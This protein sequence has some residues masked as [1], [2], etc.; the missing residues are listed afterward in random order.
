MR[1][2]PCCTMLEPLY[3]VSIVSSFFI[4]PG[5]GCSRSSTLSG[6]ILRKVLLESVLP[7]APVSTFALN[8]WVP[9]IS[10]SLTCSSVNISARLSLCCWTAS[11]VNSSNSLYNLLGSLVSCLIS[12][13][14]FDCCA[15]YSESHAVVYDCASY[16]LGRIFSCFHF[17]W[18]TSLPNDP[19]FHKP[20]IWYPR[21]G[22]FLS[23]SFVY[24]H[25]V[26]SDFVL[27]CLSP[28]Y[29]FPEFCFI[30]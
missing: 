30:W 12:S 3:A 18:C 8:V 7:S 27:F 22:I 6:N 10:G 1:I 28:D 5:I 25:I 29:L 16:V 11:N 4:E 9:G 13:R 2:E 17:C 14:R 19:F 24:F 20:N 23:D 21:I 26:Y 15:F